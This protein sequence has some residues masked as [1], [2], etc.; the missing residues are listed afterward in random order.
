MTPEEI[1]QLVQIEVQR[2]LA[3]MLGLASQPEPKIVPLRKA[4]FLL[5]YET[6]SQIYKDIENGLLRVGYEIEDRRRP[7]T[8]K[9]RY[10]VDIPA[11]LKRLKHPPE[12]RRGL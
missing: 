8:K 12:K 4:I 11:S 2:T 10:Y 9:A 5:G 6:S 1:V 3:E 7:G